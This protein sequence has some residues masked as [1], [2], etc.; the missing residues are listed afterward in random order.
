MYIYIYTINAV[1][2]ATAVS[3]TTTFSAIMVLTTMSAARIAMQVLST[4]SGALLAPFAEVTG[5]AR[6]RVPPGIR[7]VARVL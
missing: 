7:V 6:V 3:A 5:A 2:A 1:S 4:A